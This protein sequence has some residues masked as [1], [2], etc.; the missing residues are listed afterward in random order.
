MRFRIAAMVPSANIASFCRSTTPFVLTIRLKITGNELRYE[1]ESNVGF[2]ATKE[3][4]LT[5]KAE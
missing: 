4:A 1:A 2:G 5:G 3:P